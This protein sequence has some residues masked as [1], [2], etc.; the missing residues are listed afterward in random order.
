M[1]RYIIPF[2]IAALLPAMAF[3]DKVQGT[4]TLT[5]PNITAVCIYDTEAK[6]A[7]LGNGYNACINHY[8]DGIL[9]I[10]GTVQ[11]NSETYKVVIGQFAFRL[12]D[13]F[14]K[15]IV[16]EGVEHIGDYAFVGCSSVVSIQ[17]PTTLQTIGAGA[18]CNLSSLKTM[19]CMG[20]TAP[21]W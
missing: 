5:S 18:F 3:A 20:G 10:P 16:Q 7:T 19:Y 6:T 13:K 14:T 9:S 15:I 11:Y 12:C 8:E 1:K 4:L 21:N 2:I 17:L